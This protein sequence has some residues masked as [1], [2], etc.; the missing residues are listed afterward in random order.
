MKE[1][2]VR[3]YSRKE[4]NLN[5]FTYCRIITIGHSGKGKFMETVIRS[6]VARDFFWGVGMNR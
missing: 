2:Y 6:V 4:A 1:S 3:I 5:K